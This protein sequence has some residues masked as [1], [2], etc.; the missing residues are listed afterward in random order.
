MGWSDE[1]RDIV[2][3]ACHPIEQMIYE[4]RNCVRGV[5]TGQETNIDLANYLRTLAE[6]LE[7]AAEAVEDAPD[8]EE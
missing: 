4:V 6:E 1:V 7:S 5:Y 2:M 3:D 8:D